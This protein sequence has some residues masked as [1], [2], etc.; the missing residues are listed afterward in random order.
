MI[1]KNRRW[2]VGNEKTRGFPFIFRARYD[3]NINEVVLVEGLF[4]SQRFS[5]EELEDMMAILKKLNKE[6]REDLI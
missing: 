2:V 3:K 6:K 1:Y 5:M 4:N